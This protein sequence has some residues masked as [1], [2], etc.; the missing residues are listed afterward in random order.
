MSD[1]PTVKLIG[2]DGNAFFVL[3]RCRKAARVA[4]WTDERIDAV[5]K[6]M[7]GG[8]YSNLLRVALEEFE[9]T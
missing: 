2:E 3:G 6:R 1:K 5:T 8:D 7:Q 9:V 4:G